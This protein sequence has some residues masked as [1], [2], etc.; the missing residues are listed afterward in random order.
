MQAP[1]PMPPAKRSPR[2]AV[3]QKAIP[4]AAW[5]GLGLLALMWGGSFPAT[6]VL[7]AKLPALTIAAFR[8]TFGACFLWI[9]TLSRGKPL[10]RDWR[11][12]ALFIGIGAVNNVT[13]FFLISWGQQHIPAGLAA[14]LNASTAVF[15]VIVAAIAF[16][17]ER[18]TPRKV[19]GVLLGL[20]GVAT[21][22]GLKALTHFDL[23]SLAQLSLIGAALAYAVGGALSRRF[24]TDI[25]P[26]VAAA[27]MLS[28]AACV[29]L[30]LAL[31]REGIP[32]ISLTLPVVLAGSY[33]SIIATGVAYLGYYRVLKLAGSG[34]TTLVTLLVA[35][36][37]ILLGTVFFG[38]V[39]PLDAYAGLALIAAGLIVI[40]GR[41]V[42]A[43]TSARKSPAQPSA[44]PPA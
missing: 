12:W 29:A 38:D 2:P 23:T 10:P 18:L 22:I 40:D 33:L 15:G 41:L 39:L 27:G 4:P 1:T 32:D 25:A 14:I 13:P 20:A 6:S 36:V 9:W 3:A 8:I 31:L 37:S 44:Q 42:R 24:L 17:D 35:P 5:L 43:L 21:V 28:G 11:L 7:A 16:R 30:P 19:T 34:N 26:E